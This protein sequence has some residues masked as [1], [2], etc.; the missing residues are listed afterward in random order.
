MAISI[1]SVARVMLAGPDSRPDDSYNTR[2]Q[3]IETI[4]FAT[5]CS[6]VDAAL[7]LFWLERI[8]AAARLRDYRV[9]CP[10]GLELE[11]RCYLLFAKIFRP[12][13]AEPP[14]WLMQQITQYLLDTNRREIAIQHTHIGRRLVHGQV[15]ITIRRRP[16]SP[17]FIPVFRSDASRQQNAA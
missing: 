8:V 2:R 4:A 13:N 9:V 7:L 11:T 3:L 14:N 10:Y 12:N 15:V 16:L 17:T 6:T 5:S 1:K